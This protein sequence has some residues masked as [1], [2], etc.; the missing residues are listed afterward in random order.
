MQYEAFATLMELNSIATGNTAHKAEHA[1]HSSN[2]VSWADVRSATAADPTLQSVLQLLVS[3]FPAD[4]RT[5]PATIRPYFPYS[6]SL[7]E[8][9]GVLMLSVR[10][11]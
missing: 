7:Y 1:K 11:P 10:Y 2:V 8:L 6:S 4:S 5:L 3:G 9:D